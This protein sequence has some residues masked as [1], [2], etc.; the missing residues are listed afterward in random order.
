MVSSSIISEMHFVVLAHACDAH[1]DTA[2]KKAR[3]ACTATV[4]LLL[5]LLQWQRRHPCEARP[6]AWHTG[7]WQAEKWLMARLWTHSGCFDWMQSSSAPR[8][9][10]KRW[11]QKRLDDVLWVPQ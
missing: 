5:L 8:W 6:P 9:L 7:G 4:L 1:R 10:Q 11:L 3:R 2:T